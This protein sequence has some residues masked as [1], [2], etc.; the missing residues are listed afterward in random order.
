MRRQLDERLEGLTRCSGRV[1]RAR[2]ERWR[3]DAKRRSWHGSS[4]SVSACAG[5]YA[6]APTFRVVLY[7]PTALER[8]KL[9]F[10]AAPEFP[11]SVAEV[12]GAETRARTKLDSTLLSALGSEPI[13]AHL[14]A[15]RFCAMSRD[16]SGQE[17]RRPFPAPR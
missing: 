6:H 4:Q 13:E 12:T 11:G 17:P 15:D 16:I 9:G 1:E 10:V 8:R 3:N 14:R 5:E 2:E 7:L